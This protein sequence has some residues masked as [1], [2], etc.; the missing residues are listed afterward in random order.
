MKKNDIILLAVI[1]VASCVLLTV[2][3]IAY[4]GSG[5]EVVVKVDG[6]E[7]A[8]LPLDRDAELRIDSGHGYNLLIIK[9]G[10]AFISDA[11]CPD[12]ICVKTGYADELKSIV[13]LP[14]KVT[15]SIEK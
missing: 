14:N 8:R 2:F 11:S 15:V 4:L 13:C 10:K 5:G 7:Y 12:L 3:C 1:I 6:K 9:D